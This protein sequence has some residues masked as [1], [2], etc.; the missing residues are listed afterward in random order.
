MTIFRFP[1][2]LV[3]HLKRFSNSGYR[4]EK[5]STLINI[6]EKLDMRDYKTPKSNHS[7]LK[8]ASQYRLYG[9]SHHSGSLN[10][11]HYIGEV[12]NVDDK[13]WY[14]CNDS[15]CTKIRGGADKQSSSAYVLFYVRS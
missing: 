15:Q 14:N 3:L 2:V 10:G 6:P 11:G 13:T 7:S 12:M 5:I 1:K 9:M 4:R 8:A